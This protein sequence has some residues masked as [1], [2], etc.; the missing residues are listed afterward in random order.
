MTEPEL[1]YAVT[2]TTVLKARSRMEALH[3]TRAV[4]KPVCDERYMPKVKEIQ[5]IEEE[6]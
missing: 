6:S 5:Q 4:C 2:V 3:R 1:L